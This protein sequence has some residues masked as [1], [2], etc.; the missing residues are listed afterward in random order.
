MP[1]R[2]NNPKVIF[3]PK[4]M[5]IY[6]DTCIVRNALSLRNKED[7]FFLENIRKSNIQC[8]T[9]IYTF[10]ELFE[11]AK[12]RKF[13]LKLVEEKWLEVNT[14]MR[15]RYQKN[16][17]LDELFSISEII[18]SLFIKYDFI[19]LCNI[20]EDQEWNLAKEICEKSNLHMSDV[21][22]L[23]TAYIN[24]CTHIATRDTFFIKE[25]NEIL[26]ENDVPL[27][28][29]NICLPEDIIK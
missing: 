5:C 21:L 10:L 15:D 19:E 20:T 1:K 3:R 2:K 4:N 11:I 29:L 14:F 24:K 16:L 18:N 27:E 13:L 26:R 28:E 9:S 17:S 23:A 6:L 8:K 7:I 22:H 25:G 12:D